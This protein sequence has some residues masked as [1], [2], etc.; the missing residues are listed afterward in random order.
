[1]SIR[2]L[3][4]T[5]KAREFFARNSGMFGTLYMSYSEHT[6]DFGTSWIYEYLNMSITGVTT[7]SAIAVLLTAFIE[8]RCGR[9]PNCSVC[10]ACGNCA[11]CNACG[12]CGSCEATWEL[13]EELVKALD[14]VSP[15]SLTHSQILNSF[16][17]ECIDRVK[18]SELEHEH[19]LLASVRWDQHFILRHNRGRINTM[20]AQPEQ[21]PVT[22]EFE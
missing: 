16:A 14:L 17:Y 9:V 1:M 20:Y 3:V 5:K 2:P 22:F 19:W 10:N 15:V 8:H 4:L 13:H 11:N 6:F 21:R 12:S 7:F 18:T